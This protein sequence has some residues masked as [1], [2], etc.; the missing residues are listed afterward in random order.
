MILDLRRYHLQT[1]LKVGQV[2]ERQ[3]VSVNVDDTCRTAIEFFV[4]HRIG[5]LPVVDRS[6]VVRGILSETDLILELN[7]DLRV[8]DIMTREVITIR[9]DC[10]L[11]HVI[12]LFQTR[13]NRCFP[14]VDERGKLVGVIGRKDVLA[15]YHKL[16]E[17]P[18]VS[19]GGPERRDA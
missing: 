3:V 19:P 10:N 6:L 14:V 9:E 17:S 15:Y 4:R 18:G 8:S 11:A 1:R 5:A 7:Y 12:R 2:M 13:R 16:Q